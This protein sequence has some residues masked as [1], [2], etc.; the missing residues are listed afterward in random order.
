MKILR[1]L[2]GITISLTLI[3]SGC[4][5]VPVPHPR[6]HAYGVKGQVVSATDGIPIAA[7]VHSIDAPTDIVRCDA[8][9]CFQVR[10]RYGWHGAYFI[11]VISQSMLPGW[12]VTRPVRGICVSTPGYQT[13][14]LTVATSP[15][16][17]T[18]QVRA[19]VVGAYLLA[20]KISLVPV[21]NFTSG[22]EMPPAKPVN[23]KVR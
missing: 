10:P 20:G 19:E 21:T 1:L 12:D 4:M 16:S 9:G 3:C 8:E 6:V 15:G 11:G 17:D 22:G 7:A 14:T 18:G 13:T 5:I 2:S 23:D